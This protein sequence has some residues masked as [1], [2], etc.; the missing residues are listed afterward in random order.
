MKRHR[1]FKRIAATG[2]ALIIAIGLM[3]GGNAYAKDKRYNMTYLY[4][5]DTRT[6]IRNVDKAKDNLHTVSPSYFDL[7]DAGNLVLNGIIDRGF[8]EAM[9]E[10]DIRVVP[11]LSNHWDRAKGRA[12]LANRKALAKQVADAVI[13]YGFHGVN[14][15]IENVT[16]ADREAYTDFV[17]LVREELP[18]KKEVS[19]A[20]AANPKG[21]NTGWQ[22]SYDYEALERYSDYLMIMA[23]D[24]NSEGGAQ[25]PVASISFVENAIKYALRH[26]PAHKIVLGVPFYGRYWK[27]GQSYGGYGL[28]L[29]KVRELLDRFNGRVDFDEHTASP[30]ATVTI[31]SQNGNYRLS[32]SSLTPGTYV[33]WFENEESIKHKLRLVQKYGLKGTGSW[34]LGQETVDTWDY[35]GIWL[36]GNWFVDSYGHWAQEE[37]ADMEERGWMQGISSTHFAPDRPLTRAQAAAIMVRAM[38]LEDGRGTGQF[39]DVTGNH[40]AYREIGI[41]QKHG[42]MQGK[43]SGRFGPEDPLTR[44]EMAVILERIIDT[45]EEES[46]EEEV[47]FRDID[48]NRWSYPAIEAMFRQEIFMGYDDGTFKP[49]DKITRGQMA[50]LMSRIARYID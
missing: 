15:D 12:A 6:F 9:E 8:V 2:T 7:D 18:S 50:A 17:R 30:K 20:V 29:T 16:E 3:F 23:Y 33:V 39:T 47:F 26:V 34:S 48:E 40:W 27:V 28:H 36:N 44:E 22:G 11:F 45:G 13:E 38:D 5:G 4:F 37:I 32:G 46:D 31:G 25:G 10:R 24:E 41:A 1:T 49:F 42:I 19:V 35:Y 14:V 21:I 43:G